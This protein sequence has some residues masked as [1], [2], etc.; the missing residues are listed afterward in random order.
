[1]KIRSYFTAPSI[2]QF[3]IGLM[4]ILPFLL[5]HHSHPIQALY[6]EWIVAL[7]AFFA[8]I[9][10]IRQTAWPSYQAPAIIAL[11]VGMLVVMALQYAVLDIAYWQHYL[12]VAQYF[13]FAALMMLLGSMLKQAIGFERTIQG[14]AWAILTSGLINCVIITL[15]LLGI[16]ADGLVMDT[17]GGGAIANIGQQ[18]HLAVLLA[19]ALSSSIYLFIKQKLNSVIAWLFFIIFISGL[20]LTTSRSTWLYIGLITVAC[21]TYRYVQI[22]QSNI[23]PVLSKRLFTMVLLPFLFYSVQLGLPHLPLA[24]EIKTTNQRLVEL[25]KQ[26]ESPRLT[27]YKASWYIFTD[28]PLLGVGFGQMAWHDLNNASRVPEYKGTNLQSHNTILQLLVET[29]VL[30]TTLFLVCLIA[31]LK[32]TK[33]STLNQERALWWLIL[34]VIAIHGMLEFPLAYMHFLA[35]AALLLGMADTRLKDIS[36]YRPQLNLTIISV[37]WLVC[38]VQIMHDY[39]IIERWFYQ[40]HF[41]KFNDERFD[42]MV[43]ELRPVRAFSPLA[44]YADMQLLLSMPA[45]RN[46]LQ[47]KLAATDRMLK[48]YISPVLAYNYATLLALD[49]RLEQA[50]AHL[51]NVYLRFPGNIQQYW[52]Q[53]VKQTLSGEVKLFHLVKHIELLRDGLDPD[54][55]APDIDYEQFKK[56]AMETMVEPKYGYGA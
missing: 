23:S 3:F 13:V 34:G 37:V 10:L 40:S 2:S 56:P 1:L 32:A 29:G 27:I 49:G 53:T 28:N 12:L 17:K 30:G 44:S 33:N 46:S 45:D 25:A 9:P 4:L 24:K 36:R 8:F 19:F 39:R 15:D 5:P 6:L 20:A 50:K 14:I 54:Y 55:E 26:N 21:I 31:F 41:I 51:N 52:Q 11:P 38:L 18:N 48:V 47:E 16:H 22:K 43:K 35:L 42:R 7:M